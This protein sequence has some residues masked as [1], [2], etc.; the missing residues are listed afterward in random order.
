MIEDQGPCPFE[1]E[2]V[3]AEVVRRLEAEG[4][5]EDPVRQFIVSAFLPL[6]P[7]IPLLV[8]SFEEEEEG[9]ESLL[10]TAQTIL[11]GPTLRWF[12]LDCAEVAEAGEL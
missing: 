12:M 10:L 3:E 7:I 5:D 1:R 11:R 4:V 6:F 2:E 9:N 8:F